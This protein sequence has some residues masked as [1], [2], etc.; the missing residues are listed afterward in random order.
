MSSKP[1]NSNT[2]KLDNDYTHK[3]INGLQKLN[4]GD[5]GEVDVNVEQVSV[6]QASKLIQQNDQDKKL[7][8]VL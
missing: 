2:T 7:A 3:L 4:T 8:F 6:N 5:L 1:S